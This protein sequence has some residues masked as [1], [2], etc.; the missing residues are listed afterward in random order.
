VNIALFGGTFDPVHRGHI[1]VAESATQRFELG[2]VLFIPA[3][4]PPLKGHETFASF[5]HR[6][7]M[8]ALATSGHRTF[9][10]L[11]LEAQLYAETGTPNYSLETVRRLKRELKKADKLYFLIGIDAFLGVA[12][13]YRPVELLRECD[14]IVASR[15]GYSLGDIAGALPEELRPR[16]VVL[17]A[18]KSTA[19]LTEYGAVMSFSGVTLH[20]LEDVSERVSSTQLRSAAASS[21]RRLEAYVGDAVAEYIRKN[22][23]YRSPVKSTSPA[24]EPEIS[25]ASKKK[26]RR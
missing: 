25:N 11:D 1:V 15:P 21:G 26:S 6:M 23:L 12:K 24:P 9:I 19:G 4:L 10:P 22:H 2:K 18:G 14:F 17:K 5:A 20:L 8:V 3:A 16:A 7:A 13:W